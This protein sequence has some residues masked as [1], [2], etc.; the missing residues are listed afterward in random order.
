MWGGSPDGAMSGARPGRHHT[1]AGSAIN[2]VNNNNTTE[3]WYTKAN[4]KY[5]H[6]G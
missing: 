2:Q 3:K 1:G 5:V 4:K 6:L